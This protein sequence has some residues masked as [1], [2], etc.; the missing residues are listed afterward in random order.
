MDILW[1]ADVPMTPRDVHDLLRRRRQGVAYTTVMTILV[2]LW[3]KRMLTRDEH[4][5]AFAY[6]PVAT[7]EE[8]TAQRMHEVLHGSGDRA[9]ALTHFVRSIDSREAA[10]LR[11]ALARRRR[12]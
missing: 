8:W 6:A 3:K 9:A 12:S 7:R 1:A 11:R 4:G 10:Q 5:R 2:R